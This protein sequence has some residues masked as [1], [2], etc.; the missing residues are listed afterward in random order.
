[1][2]LV[3]YIL[4]LVLYF[5]GSL[6]S[7]RD[8]GFSTKGLGRM[9]SCGAVLFA[10]DNSNNC[11]AVGGKRLEITPDITSADVEYDGLLFGLTECLNNEWSINDGVL[12][13]RGDCKAI[14][15]QWNGKAVPRKL[16]PKHELAMKLIER[17]GMQVSFEHVTRED[18]VLC[19]SIC[20]AVMHI[21]EEREVA[22]FRE[23]LVSLAHSTNNNKLQYQL[24]DLLRDSLTSEKSLM[25]HS[26]RPNLYLEVVDVARRLHDGIAMEYMGVQL[27]AE[28]KFWKQQNSPIN[29]DLMAA[30]GI[31]WQVQGLEWMGNDKRAKQILQKHRF[32]LD[33]FGTHEAIAKSFKKVCL[34]L[35]TAKGAALFLNNLCDRDREALEIWRDEANTQNDDSL[36]QGYW[37]NT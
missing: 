16:L 2:L 35:D 14:I 15:D 28:Q 29:K 24:L 1:M 25:R 11:L 19:D 33:S 36:R 17:M 23:K 21:S 9:A 27:V 10:H 20:A 26:V 18:N 6:R 8:A 3:P 30:Q 32:L 37:M 12:I 4:G 7:P 31:L 34:R 5:D 22:R 13:V